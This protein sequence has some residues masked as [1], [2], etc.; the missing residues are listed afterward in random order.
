MGLVV[1]DGKSNNQEDTFSQAMQNRD[2]GI[3]M[4]AL[5]VGGNYRYMLV[6]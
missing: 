2:R 6:E 4:L 3:E 1:T 5:G